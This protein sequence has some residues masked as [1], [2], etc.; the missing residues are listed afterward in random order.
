VL[1]DAGFDSQEN[2]EESQQ[3]LSSPLPTAINPRRSKPLKAIKE[4]TKRLFK[5]H[6]DEI[7]SPYDALER[8]PQKQLIEYGVEV[9]SVEET[10]IRYFPNDLRAGAKT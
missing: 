2:R 3:R 5:K 9:G 7:A 1:A 6:G 10:Y 8:L 4:E